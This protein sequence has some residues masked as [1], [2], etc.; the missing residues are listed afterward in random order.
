[1]PRQGVAA[2]GAE[3]QGTQPQAREPLPWSIE[4]CNRIADA[5]CAHRPIHC[6]TCA[7]ALLAREL[8]S[9][10]PGAVTIGFACPN[11]RVG[12]THQLGRLDPRDFIRP[13]YVKCPSCGS[14]EFGVLMVHRDNFTRRCRVRECWHTASYVLPRLKK[15]VIY[16]DQHL[17]SDMMKA[18]HPATEPERRA[19]AAY[20]RGVFEVLHR[21]VKLQIVIC[22]DSYIHAKESMVTP[23]R[24]DLERMYE[25]LSCGV[26]FSEVWDI[27]VEQVV[28]HARNWHRGDPNTPVKLAAEDVVEGDLHGWHDSIMIGAG[29]EPDASAVTLVRTRRDSIAATLTPAY[30]QWVAHGGSFDDY[31]DD[32]IREFPRGVAKEFNARKQWMRGVQAGIMR[33]TA[34]DFEGPLCMEYLNG[35]AQ[36]LL[37][38]GLELRAAQERAME[39]FARGDHSSLPFLHIESSMWA[40][41]AWQSAH[42]GRKKKLGRGTS[43][44]LSAISHFL[45][46]CDAMYV[47]NEMRGVTADHRV[48]QQLGSYGTRMFS[49][50]NCDE[51]VAYVEGL[52]ADA[53]AEHFALV[54]RVYGENC[55]E[56]FTQ[57]YDRRTGS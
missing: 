46:Y 37:D 9:D 17:I 1:M 52:V 11:C 13:P 57:L 53:P 14:A 39:Y 36:A 45:P 22:P 30:Q 12:V 18:L 21:A 26:S 20:A 49:R 41:L 2:V 24:K 31:R 33:P 34:E 56:P 28:E 55:G 4:E 44:D 32:M 3:H 16:L 50:K 48:A 40:F 23:H 10:K 38:E 51:F 47:D 43:N 29:H 42:G 8:G 27:K 6:P 19:R 54:R 35:I 15:T 25:Q 5:Y 7:A